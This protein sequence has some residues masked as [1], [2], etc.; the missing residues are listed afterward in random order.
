MKLDE[1]IE[2]INKKNISEMEE[3][4]NID[5]SEMRNCMTEMMHDENMSS[6]LYE[7]LTQEGFLPDELS[8]GEDNNSICEMMMDD[9]EV[10]SEMYKSCTGNMSECGMSMQE[11]LNEKLYGGQTALDKNHNGELDAQDFSILRGSNDNMDEDGDG[12]AMMGNEDHESGR[13]MFFAGL[14]QIKAQ[15][16]QLLGMDQDEVEQTLNDGHDWAQDHIATAKES[17]DQVFDFFSG[18]V[19]DDTSSDNDSE[20]QVIT[21]DGMGM[22]ED[23]DYGSSYNKY[24]T[25]S[26]VQ[27]QRD[28]IGY[29]DDTDEENVVVKVEKAVVYDNGRYKPDYYELT[30]TNGFKV[31]SSFGDINGSIGVSTPE[32]AMGEPYDSFGF[33]GGEEDTLAE[34]KLPDFKAIKGNN[35]DTDNKNNAKKDNNKE[36]K[37]AEKSQKTKEEKTEEKINVKFS[38]DMESD[39]QKGVEQKRLGAFNNLN[40]DFQN[41]VPDSYKKRVEMEVKTGLS[42]DRDEEKYGKFG[43]VDYESTERVGKAI[44]DASQANQGERDDFYK[45]NPITVTKTPYEQTSISG[46][47]KGGKKVSG[48]GD[49]TNESINREID[50]M[51]KIFVYEDIQLTENKTKTLSEDDILLQSVSKKKFI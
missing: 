48:G 46:K 24:N 30:F 49:L 29:D 25:D 22:N 9:D 50:R 2:L 38:P 28:E 39:F 40:L 34:A 27:A 1:S 23:D 51:K 44:W 16:E 31:I 6:C 11:W 37:D 45:P 12:D 35:V 26:W 18:G 8:E 33:H 3:L 32:E 4:R 14:E 47:P 20:K 10:M 21:Q 42:R 17:I 7:V 19:G 15:C 5:V 43:N 41:E 13:Y 36:I